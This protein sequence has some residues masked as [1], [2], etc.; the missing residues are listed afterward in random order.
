MTHQQDWATSTRFSRPLGHL[1]EV[2]TYAV[3]YGLLGLGVLGA[4]GHLALGLAFF[5][6]TFLG[7]MLLCLLVAGSV[8]RDRTALRKAWLYPMRDLMGFCF[9]IGSYFGSCRLR[10]RGDPY[11]LLPQGRLRR[12][13][14]EPAE[15]APARLAS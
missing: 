3:P 1:G 13:V 12:L 14:E 4:A 11:Q 15:T 9:W 2:L 6:F 10:Y 5:A 8:V 7:R